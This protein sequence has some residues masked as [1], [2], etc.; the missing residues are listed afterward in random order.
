M[1]NNTALT[2]LICKELL[3]EVH[4]RVFNGQFATFTSS[5]VFCI[6]I[7]PSHMVVK[8]SDAIMASDFSKSSAMKKLSLTGFDT[9]CLSSSSGPLS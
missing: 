2:K 1:Q 6:Y 3:T 5:L 4:K 8:R 7:L 9:I